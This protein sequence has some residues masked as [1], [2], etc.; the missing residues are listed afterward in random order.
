MKKLEIEEWMGNLG[1]EL[2]NNGYVIEPRLRIYPFI[3]Y[4]VWVRRGTRGLYVDVTKDFLRKGKFK[5][6]LSQVNSAFK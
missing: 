5:K 2:T 4:E 6:L 1:E 3:G